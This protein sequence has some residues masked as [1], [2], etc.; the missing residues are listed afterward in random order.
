METEYKPL[1]LITTL[2]KIQVT[3]EHLYE[4][5]GTVKQGHGSTISK[6]QT[7]EMGHTNQLIEQ[8]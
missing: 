2:Q 5:Q 7:V 8:K 1:A 6:I 3:E 4:I